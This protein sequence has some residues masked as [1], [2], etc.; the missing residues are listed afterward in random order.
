MSRE[1]TLNTDL[2]K[3]CEVCG[4]KDSFIQVN[5]VIKC[6]VCGSEFMRG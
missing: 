3:K 5:D 6:D 4:C 2:P 1:Y